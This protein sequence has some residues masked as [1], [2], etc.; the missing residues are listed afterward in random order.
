[1]SAFRRWGQRAWT[2]LL[3]RHVLSLTGRG[4]TAAFR[5]AT[6]MLLARLL[7]AEGLGAWILYLTTA[8]FLHMCRRGLVKTGLVRY[9][10]GRVGAGR[11]SIVGAGWVLAAAL[12]ALAS[13][14]VALW[15]AALPV[16]DGF[17]LFVQ[18]YP[19]L[20]WA[21]LPVHMSTWL[22]EADNRFDRVLW[23]DLMQGAGL[24]LVLM[25]LLGAPFVF[26][27]PA[28]PVAPDLAA[29]LHVGLTGVASIAALGAGWGRLAA[30]PHATV[31]A[32]GRLFAFGRYSVGT[33]IGTH[34][35]TSSDTYLLGALAG[36]AAVGLYGVAQK[37]VRLVQV[38]LRAL[39]ATAYPALAQRSRGDG[40]TA[41]SRYAHRW[42]LL[43]T[44]ALLPVLVVLAV[45]APTWVG[46]LGGDG[47]AGA[48]PVLQWFVLYLA[49]APLDRMV[50]LLFDSIEKPHLNL[51]KV[52]VM[53][54]VNVVG[55]V[56]VYMLTGSVAAVAAVT[57]LTLT[58]GVVVGLAMLPAEA[59]L[60]SQGVRQAAMRLGV[61]LR[62][63][64]STRG[65]R[66]PRRER[67][68]GTSDP[69]IQ[70]GDSSKRA[71]SVDS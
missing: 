47:Y 69:S 4:A 51:V 12:T 35:L 41:L 38:P 34:L 16:P 27:V 36:P 71:H 8:S 29:G 49:L 37:A 32:L 54:A 56:L 44:A 40:T 43:V 46:L 64:L 60:R 9:V 28:V 26:A 10:T 53:L 63:I 18:W 19:W 48:V 55:D 21:V 23:M 6:F 7:G 30:L 62:S 24:P 1:M 14:A 68:E 25:G 11:R 17:G 61:R 70:I 20:A 31:S 65:R 39:S 57:T 22:A 33:L 15:G 45:W 59:T 2:A 13:G 58:A 42:V 3:N 52:G 50:G 66:S 67:Q 5:V